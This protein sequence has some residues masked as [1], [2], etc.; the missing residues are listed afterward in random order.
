MIEKESYYTSTKREYDIKKHAN[1]SK[2]SPNCVE[3]DH[4][5]YIAIPFIILN[6]NPIDSDTPTTILSDTYSLNTW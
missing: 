4:H 3:Q 2:Y 5:Q 6:M 1:S